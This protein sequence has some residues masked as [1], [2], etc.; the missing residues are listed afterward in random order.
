M[1]VLI[2]NET[3]DKTTN[4]SKKSSRELYSQNNEANDETKIPKE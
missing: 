3:A 2:G 1:A 4:L